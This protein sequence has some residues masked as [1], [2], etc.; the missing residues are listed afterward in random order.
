MDQSPSIA[1]WTPTTTATSTSLKSVA[2][3]AHSAL[4]SS[5][6]KALHSLTGHTTTMERND[7]IH[8]SRAARGAQASLSIIS[9]ENILAT[10]TAESIK[11]QATEMIW[12][13]TQNLEDLAWDENVYDIRRLTRPETL[14]FG[15][16]A[17]SFLWYIVILAKSRYWWFNVA[18]FCGAA[19]EFGV[20]WQ[21]SLA[22]IA[23]FVRCIYRVVE[24]AQ[25]FS[26]YLITHE[27]YI[28]CLDALML[29][30]ALYM[31]IPFHP[32]IV[33]GA[34]NIIR[35]G[36]I[37]GNTDEKIEEEVLYPVDD[38]YDS[39]ATR[40]GTAVG[41]PYGETQ[42]LEKH[43]SETSYKADLGDANHQ[44]SYPIESD[45]TPQG[46]HSANNSHI[47]RDS[48]PLESREEY[49]DAMVQDIG[50]LWAVWY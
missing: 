14:S 21:I 9:G 28:M 10:A 41:S 1:A 16:F 50:N 31:F 33:F 37:K 3:S 27:V 5:L 12:N 42:D 44:A 40:K 35:L 11:A 32:H 29:F 38:G 17:I 48:Y 22:I 4:E 23:V 8:A 20:P 39:N 7:Y 24:L 30:I 34:S 19:L 36:D 45:Y 43:G 47:P 49:H 2:T 26:G 15:V 46:I 18:F 25:G 13:S 6:S